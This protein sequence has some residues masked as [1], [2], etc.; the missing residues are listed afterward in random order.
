MEINIAEIKDR[1]GQM[2]GA[3]R[4][5]HTLA[6]CDTAVILAEWFDADKEKAYLAALLHDCAR[7]FDEGQLKEAT[8]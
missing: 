4:L 1:L 8:V 3:K 2:L 5:A 7:G 6:V